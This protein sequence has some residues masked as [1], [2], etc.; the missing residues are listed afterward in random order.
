M[1]VR[2][3]ACVSVCVRASAR[4]CSV[5]VCACVCVCVMHIFCKLDKRASKGNNKKILFTPPSP[6][7]R[8]SHVLYSINLHPDT[9]ARPYISQ[10]TTTT[11]TTSPSRRHHHHPHSRRRHRH[12]KINLTTSTSKTNSIQ[13]HCV[14]RGPKRIIRVGVMPVLRVKG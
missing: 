6:F 12:H 1:C 8:N 9:A 10:L 5:C 14:F 7:R 13:L 4:V 2:A 3:R 11:T